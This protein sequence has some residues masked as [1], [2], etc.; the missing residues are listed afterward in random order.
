[1]FSEQKRCREVSIQP[2]EESSGPSPQTMT[3]M[4]DTQRGRHTDRQTHRQA[5]AQTHR[6]TL[7][8]KDRETDQQGQRE[9]LADRYRQTVIQSDRYQQGVWCRGSLG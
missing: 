6:Q 3:Q 7:S 5:A 1:M 4:M 9:R 8:H 2:A